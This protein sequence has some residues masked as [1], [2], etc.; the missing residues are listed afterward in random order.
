[1][2]VKVKFKLDEQHYIWLEV[3]EEK[4]PDVKANN[5]E[6]SRNEKRVIRHESKYSFETYVEYGNEIADMIVN[7]EEQL[8][9]RECRK[10]MHEKLKNAIRKL[11][12]RQREAVKKVFIEGKKQQEAA[13]EM[14]ITESTL[15]R[16]ISRAIANL[17]NNLEK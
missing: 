14:G 9:E 7:A 13:C 8:I 11:T 2:K 1:M 6:I 3:D 15:S 4:L 5:R 12:R 16:T 17:K 10:E